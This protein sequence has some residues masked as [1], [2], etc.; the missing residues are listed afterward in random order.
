M[1]ISALLTPYGF[2]RIIPHFS[3][4]VYECNERMYEDDSRHDDPLGKTMFC[5]VAYKR[6]YYNAPDVRDDEITLFAK[7]PELFS[8]V[9]VAQHLIQIK[10]FST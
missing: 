10:G 2:V 4:D 5:H 9:D 8:A 3:G 7:R 6:I 1:K